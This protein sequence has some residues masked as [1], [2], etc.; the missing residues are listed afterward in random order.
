MDSRGSATEKVWSQSHTSS[1]PTIPIM[2]DVYQS[3]C[4]SSSFNSFEIFT[5]INS[6]NVKSHAVTLSSYINVAF[7]K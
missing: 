6:V 4:Y 1:S 3:V 5:V 2:F 7:L